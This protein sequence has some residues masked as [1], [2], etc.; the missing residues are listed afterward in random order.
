MDRRARIDNDLLAGLE[1]LDALRLHR[2]LVTDNRRDARLD[3][4]RAQGQ[5]EDRDDEGSDGMSCADDGRN[6]S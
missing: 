2:R 5:N 3:E 1:R 6:S 4:P